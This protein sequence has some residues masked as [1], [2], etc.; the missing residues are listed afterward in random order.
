MKR[1]VDDSQCVSTLQFNKILG[2]SLH[3]TELK[4]Q[5][6]LNFVG[7]HGLETNYTPPF[8]SGI[9]FRDRSEITHIVFTKIKSCRVIFMDNCPIFHI[10][11]IIFLFIK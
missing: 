6:G 9:S 4:F 11:D 7:L 10:I 5:T 2:V 8:Q 1:N 3:L